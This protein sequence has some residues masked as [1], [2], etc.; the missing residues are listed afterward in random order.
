MSREVHPGKDLRRLGLGLLAGLLLGCQVPPTPIYLVE[1]PPAD[2]KIP[3]PPP[4]PRVEVPPAAPGTEAIWQQG[5]WAWSQD[6]GEYGWV[7]GTWVT[8]QPGYQLVPVAYLF[9]DGSWIFRPPYWHRPRGPRGVPED[10]SAPL[11]TDGTRRAPPSTADHDPRRAP[12]STADHDPRRAPPST[13]DHDPRRAPPSTADHDPRRAPPSTADQ[14]PR[15]APPS[16]AD[17]D[18]R[19]APP[20]TGSA[21]TTPASS[22]TPIEDPDRAMARKKQQAE[23]ERLPERREPK[24][25][26]DKTG[27]IILGEEPGRRS[28]PAPDRDEKAFREPPVRHGEANRPPPPASDPRSRPRETPPAPQRGTAPPGP[29]AH[30]PEAQPRPQQP[31]QP[32]QQPP[33]LRQQP[34]QPRQQPPVQVQSAPPPKMQRPAP[35]PP[36]PPE[37]KKKKE[38][39]APPPPPPPPPAKNAK[40]K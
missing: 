18:P 17:H 7:G 16:T 38:A 12:P 4:L 10:R 1:T 35:P 6:G 36:P 24:Y 2:V 15:R 34:P 19:R 14:D 31:P 30:R 13:A 22:G 40:H 29:P 26:T 21:G 33:Q 9:V 5:Y 8:P 25:K 23:A 3:G 39:K 28:T 37:K 20:S 32:R 11:S 27:A